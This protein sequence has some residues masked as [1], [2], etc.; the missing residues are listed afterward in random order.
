MPMVCKIIR[1]RCCMR[2]KVCHLIDL[3]QLP[4]LFQFL[5]ENLDCLQHAMNGHRLTHSESVSLT[6]L[7]TR[8]RL[9]RMVF[10]LPQV[11]ARINKR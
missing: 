10:V 9:S 4:M 7:V 2:H 8:V 5:Q 11:V 1:T 3:D 6:N